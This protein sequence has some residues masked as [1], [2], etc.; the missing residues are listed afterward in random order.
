[1][2]SW[3]LNNQIQT[4]RRWKCKTKDKFRLIGLGAILIVLILVFSLTIVQ[5]YKTCP[6]LKGCQYIV[7]DC[8][9]FIHGSEICSFK[10]HVEEIEHCK[11]N[12]CNGTFCPSTC[13]QNNPWSDGTCPKNGSSCDLNGNSGV[14]DD[15]Y[16]QLNTC[17]ILQD[18]CI[19]VVHLVILGVSGTGI[20]MIGMTM[21]CKDMYKLCLGGFKC[22][23]KKETYDESE[24]GKQTLLSDS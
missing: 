8:Q 4:T 10:I 12:Q 13:L 5:I 1:M 16:Y 15:D 23:K 20:L 6:R 19:G 24:T 9:P 3:T 11:T 18:S 17:D 21:L 14:G 2:V 7:F 22:C